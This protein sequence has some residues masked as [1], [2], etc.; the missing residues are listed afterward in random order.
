MYPILPMDFSSKFTVL[1]L[2]FQISRFRRRIV[3]GVVE[4]EVRCSR[5]LS[6]LFG[7]EVW[8]QAIR[9][10]KADFISQE[11]ITLC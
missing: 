2:D 6:F 9:H 4:Y 8:V 7:R 10:I 3:A 1:V 11:T 5:V